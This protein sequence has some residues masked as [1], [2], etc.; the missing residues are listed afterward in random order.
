MLTKLESLPD[1]ERNY[2]SQGPGQEV[3]AV[4]DST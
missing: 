3:A 1:F 4:P 2:W